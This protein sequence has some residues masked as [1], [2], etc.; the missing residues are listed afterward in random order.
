M[1]KNDDKFNIID[2]MDYYKFLKIKKLTFR[3]NVK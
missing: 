2:L 1:I 3:K